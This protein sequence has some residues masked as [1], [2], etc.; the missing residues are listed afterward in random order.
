MP[1]TRWSAKRERQY[2]HGKGSLPERGKSLRTAEPIAARTVNT[3]RAQ[4]GEAE[5]SNPKTLKDTPAPVHSGQRSHQGAQGRTP[6]QFYKDAK[7]K[8]IQGRSKMNKAE[9]ETAVGR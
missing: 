2:G 6:E 8:G 5:Q 7:R 1:Q 9:L 4:H 3:E